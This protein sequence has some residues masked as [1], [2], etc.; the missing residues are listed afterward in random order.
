MRTNT[1]SHEVNR[2]S[3]KADRTSGGVQAIVNRRLRRLGVVSQRRGPHALRHACAQRLLDQG[4]S[5]KEIG[6]HLGHRSPTSTAVYAKIDLTAPHC[7][8]WRTSTWSGWH[9]AL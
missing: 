3:R 5:F 4:L 7:A 9:D 1:W 2:N 6:D 8:K